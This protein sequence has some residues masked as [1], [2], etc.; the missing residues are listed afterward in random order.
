M[1][2]DDDSTVSSPLPAK[3]SSAAS[4]AESALDVPMSLTKKKDDLKRQFEDK[5]PTYL[6][7]YYKV[8]RA[9][10][11]IKV[12]KDLLEKTPDLEITNPDLPTLEEVIDLNRRWQLA[13]NEIEAIKVAYAVETGQ[14]IKKEVDL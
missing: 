5:Y 3:P 10:D 6:Q 11:D 14:D 13:K 9:Y 1:D 2:V 8:K 7:L 4:S 12:T